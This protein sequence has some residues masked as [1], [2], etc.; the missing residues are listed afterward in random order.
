MSIDA[1]VNHAKRFG[2]EGV[3]DAASACLTSTEYAELLRRLARMGS[4]PAVRCATPGCLVVFEPRRRDQAYCSAACKQRA[5]RLRRGASSRFISGRATY[6]SQKA[7]EGT[8]HPVD[9]GDAGAGN[10]GRDR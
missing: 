3:L 5:R 9:T 10:G 8:N 4:G 7:Q 1:Y 6:S 2:L